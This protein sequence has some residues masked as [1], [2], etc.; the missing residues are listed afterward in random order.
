MIETFINLAKIIDLLSG[1]S[2]TRIQI[3]WL[4][5]QYILHCT[6]KHVHKA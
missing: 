1:V 3:S 4:L 5:K 6:M 2:E